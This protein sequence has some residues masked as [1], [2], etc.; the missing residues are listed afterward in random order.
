ML[1]L[2]LLLNLYMKYANHDGTCD[3]LMPFRV[4]SLLILI[5]YS[6]CGTCLRVAVK[7]YTEHMRGMFMGP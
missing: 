3:I 5:H 7:V 6:A 4:F 1:S 2:H